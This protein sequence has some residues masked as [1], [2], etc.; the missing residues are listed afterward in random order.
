MS[1][2]ESRDASNPGEIWRIGALAR[3]TGLTVRTLHHYDQLGLLSPQS[4]TESG[5]RC[6]TEDDVRRL[7]RIVALR[8]LGIPLDD[9]RTLLD[10]KPD[11]TDLLRRQLAAVDERLRKL[12]DLRAR[13]TRILDHLSRDSEPS[14]R[15]LLQLIED[16]V[17]LDE[18]LTPDQF[19]ELKEHL[20]RRTD[21]WG[22]ADV[23]APIRKKKETW[24]A[25]SPA[26]R[27]R[28]VERRRRLIPSGSSMV[29]ERP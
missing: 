22:E 21:E 10:G 23:A 29:G 5:H 17:A 6:Y 27:E 26:E 24:D 16:T 20:R 25:L 12:S 14:T 13:L 9:V 1:H 2:D 18:P 4:R 15:Q 19:A 28:M 3:A 7:Q 8:S 11:P